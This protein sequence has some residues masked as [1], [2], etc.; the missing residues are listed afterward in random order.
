MRTRKLAG[1]F[2]ITMVALLV[3]GARQAEAVI[4]FDNFGPGDTF[5]GAT[6]EVTLGTFERAD[7]FIIPNFE[8][9]LDTIE[10]PLSR[11]GP[12]PNALNVFLATNAADMTPADVVEAFL[13][14]GLPEC[15]PSA[16]ALSI[17]NSSFHPAL[18]ANTKYW[19]VVDSTD[20][21]TSGFW[22]FNSIGDVGPAGLR[23]NLGDWSTTD[24]G[25]RHAFRIIGTVVPEPSSFFLLG[26]G[27]LGLAGWRR[28]R[29]C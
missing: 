19:L 27:L 14:T 29:P 20:P 2:G 5:S 10:L 16:P 22:H 26:S 23:L 8:V 24:N 28:S 13:V 9:T 12:G 4:V 15:C 25:N 18:A 17:I 1:C 11:S 6:S 21:E 3:G 7:G